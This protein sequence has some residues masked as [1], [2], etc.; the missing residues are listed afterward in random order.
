MNLPRATRTFLASTLLSGM[1]LHSA[2]TQADD[3]EIF[4]G[5]TNIDA[6]IRPNVL[7][8]LDDSL[9]MNWCLDRDSNN[10]NCS[11]TRMPTMRDTFT[12]LLTNTSGIN[13]GVMAL[14]K[15]SG[16]P[17]SR[18]LSPVQYIETSI[19][20]KLS[21]PALLESA[22]D[23]TRQT[24]SPTSTNTTDGALVMGYIKNQ[25]HTTSISRSLSNDPV[26]NTPFYSNDNST[27]YIQTSG[28]NSYT[29]SAKAADDTNVCDGAK[30][31]INARSGTGT[32]RHDGLFLFRNMNIPK[33]VTIQ[34]ATLY[35]TATAN[36]NRTFNIRVVN[37]KTP[38]AFNDSTRL[39]ASFT[40]D[41]SITSTGTGNLKSLDIKSLVQNL[42]NLA[43]SS[44]PV[45]DIA[46][47]VRSTNNNDFTY[48]IGDT[49]NSPRLEITYTGSEDNAR[50]TGLR[51][52]T[53]AIPQGA[54][55]TSARIDFVPAGSDNRQVTFAVSAQ[56]ASNASAFSSTEDF[57]VRTKTSAASWAAPEW[58]TQNPPAYVEGP[59]VRTQVQTVVSNADW[60]G[61][62]AMAFFLTPT[63]GTGSRVAYSVDAGSGL[64]PVLRVSYTGGEEGCL[65]PIVDISIL[66]P[67]DDGRQWRYDSSN[68]QRVNI[69]E[70]TLAFSDSSSHYDKTLIGA[71]FQ[72]VPVLPGATVMEAEV[73][74]TPNS[75][76]GTSAATRIHFQ[77]S[78]N[79]PA[80]AAGNNN[81]NLGSRNK[82]TGTTCTFTSQGSGIPI[83][84]KAPGIASELQGI[85]GTSNSWADG[86][87]LSLLISQTAASS[88]VLRAHETSPADAI[89]LRVKLASGGLGRNSYTVRNY[90]NDL[91]QN[92][93]P[94]GYTPI[95]PT[96]Y[97]AAR[98][99]TQRADKH[100]DTRSSPI[101]SSC[102]ATYLVLLT[103]G[104]A[105][106]NTSDAKSGIASLTGTTCASSDDGER[107]GRELVKWLATEDQSDFD[108][109]N[110]VTTHTIGF[111]LGANA[112]AQTFLDDLARSGGGKSYSASDAGGLSNAFHSIV[113]EALATNTTFVNA[114]APVNSFNRQ[115]NK[116]ELYF[117]LFR[118]SENDR[119]GGNLKRYRLRTNGSV[120]TI[121]D[122][123]N[124]PAIDP[125]TGFF[126]AN[127]LSFWTQLPEGKKDGNQVDLGGAASK[128]S[129]PDGRNLFT[130]HG[131]SPTSPVE[132]NADIYRLRAS[133]DSIT[134]EML[135]G[136][137]SGTVSTP[138]ERELLL[139]YIRG[140]DLNGT[141]V[142]KA[143]GDPIHS[144][145]RLATYACTTYNAAKQC[146]TFDQSAVIGTNEGFIHVINT[147]NGEEQMAFMPQALLKNIKQLK[148]DA[149]TTALKPKVYGMDNT[150]TLWVNDANNNGVIYGD[151]SA[152]P[153][154]SS[155]L[156]TGEF[157]YA[158]ATM[159][160]GG[161]DIYALD[162]TNRQQPRLLWQILG[163]TTPGFSRLGQTWSAPVKTKIKVGDTITD[164]L[165]FGGGYDPAQDSLNE[166]SSV[167][168]ADT[169]G[170]AI[171]IVN[172]R[173]GALIWSASNEANTGVA[174]AGSL[175][176]TNMRYSIPSG[177]RVIDMQESNGALV[178][179][180]EQLADQFFVGDMGGQVWRF[181]INNGNAASSL[182]ST[183]GSSGGV[184]ASVSDSTNPA[185][186]RRFYHEPDVAL[187]NVSGSRS[188]SVN[189]GSG[190]RGHP[191]NRIVQDRF[192]SFRTSTLFNSGTQ[193]TLTE[194]GLY[195]ATD[196]LIQ[197][198]TTEQKTAAAAAFARTDGG[199]YISLPEPGEKVLSRALIAGGDLF[200]NTYEPNTSAA[201]CK[202]AVGINRSY[203]VRLLD[204][205]PSSVA[206]DGSGTYSDRFITSKSG[207]IA[208]DP[209]I[210]CIGNTCHVLRDL[211]LEPDPVKVP[212]LGK[213]YWMDSPDLE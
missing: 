162:I 107:C 4:F 86:N 94:S 178:L 15:T 128:L 134:S 91:V 205:S 7:F 185:N 92:L 159:G 12:S 67:K 209:Q 140:Y 127:S 18:I 95:V 79:S 39:D 73:I 148:E 191:L 32:N 186:A 181:Y 187:L 106:D 202:A 111:A 13:V 69:T 172:A 5:G 51:F 135:S 196:N 57:T 211:P 171:Y 152:N 97:E 71:R 198:G 90:S 161:N 189:I 130:Y 99:L 101:T 132:L 81:N 201:A 42:Q 9:S 50:T 10:N 194:S 56:N 46:V 75:N 3:T 62:N 184:F 17:S 177:V 109:K 96:L 19:N 28:G 129:T 98:Y 102:Q 78:S 125:N 34:S 199:W 64:Q 70:S 179:D 117:A 123:D 193:S 47:R 113:Q 83:S 104:Q 133:N 155:G 38:Q 160:R 88:L 139:R 169:I 116:D 23:A 68:P 30:T 11:P 16:S 203:K 167:R 55:I 21:S 80:F 145:P 66:D 110:I 192:Y 93:N 144:S 85:F 58:R 213:T 119:W 72:K 105:N 6:G 153:P 150:V 76:S 207:G 146:T 44:N 37:S 108:G 208:G 100:T 53:V 180:A 89:K 121:V 31:S 137:Y 131:A 115:D 87:A 170:N 188:L 36:T 20:T 141:S 54:T 143:M 82:T 49:A 195:D 8:I 77:L 124:A 1:V 27:Y 190:Y 33:G 138:T 210:L 164:V 60:C 182:V 168:T 154:T 118:P 26:V 63:S 166:G 45:S 174:G 151:P 74:V 24:T 52:Q 200:F 14:N 136:G 29:C 114:T 165:I 25:P 197:Q 175:T 158:Y 206:A 41:T 183:G 142:R 147:E 149:K 48:S 65:N 163:G 204:A 126:K 156:N 120:A 122:A 40:G 22:D 35:L 157:V 103:D 61:N 43:P 84:C 2:V 173:T 212:P 176:L 112:T 59:D